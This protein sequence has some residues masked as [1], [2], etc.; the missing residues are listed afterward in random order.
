MNE[1]QRAGVVGVISS[2]GSKLR[3]AFY[4]RRRRPFL[5]VIGSR[6]YLLRALIAV[7]L[8]SPILPLDDDGGRTRE[9]F[10][11]DEPPD[12]HM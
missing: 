3:L 10:V 7:G 8:Q 5:I 2:H 12:G 9:P 1:A 6:S 11:G 4:S